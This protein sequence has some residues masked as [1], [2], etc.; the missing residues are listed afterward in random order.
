MALLEV[1][2]AAELLDELLPDELL[3]D[4]VDDELLDDELDDDELDESDEVVEAA[5]D[6]VDDEPDE[7]LEPPRLSV[8]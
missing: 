1:A 4:D 3:P 5:V 6:E 7:L 2:G 8:L